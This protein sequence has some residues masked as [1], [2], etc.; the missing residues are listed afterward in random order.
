[1]KKD[2][3][4]RGEYGLQPFNIIQGSEI[5]SQED[6]D[7]LTP[8][9]KELQQNFKKSQMFRT[10]TEMEVS[11]LNDLKFPTPA[12]KYWQSCREQNVMFSEMVMLSYEY[13]KSEIE[14]K[15][16]QRDIEKEEDELEKELLQIELEKQQFMQKGRERT[17][18]D[19]IREIKAWSEIKA[20]EADKMTDKELEDVDNH[21]LI[22]YTQRWIQQSMAAG[23]SG[24]PSER[25]NLQGQ[26]MAGIKACERQG[27]LEDALV[28]APKE[29]KDSIKK[30]LTLTE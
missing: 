13:R 12:S 9:T 1:M 23:N 18:K 8:L 26:L 27:V 2:I 3:S 14:M 21:Q 4:T 24:S 20:R 28:V 10:R 6:I 29:L 16:L 22:S 17:A 15:K 5:L 11:V 19:R 30:Q 7:S 25:Q